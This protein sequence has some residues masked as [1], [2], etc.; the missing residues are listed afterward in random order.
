MTSAPV[1]GL[2]SAPVQPMTTSPVQPIGSLL[3]V[4]PGTPTGPGSKIV[5]RPAEVQPPIALDPVESGY[6]ELYDRKKPVKLTGEVTRVEW[7]S[8]NVYVFLNA[9]GTAWIL[10]SGFVQFRQTPVWPPIRPGDFIT[11]SGY[12][13]KEDPLDRLPAKQFPAAAPYLKADRL[14]RASEIVLPSRQTLFLGLPPTDEEIAKR[15]WCL[16]G[17]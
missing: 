4:S 6:L 7:T 10:E 11:V 12:L 15:S 14:T 1:Q 17:C 5:I 13:P 3:L 8:P 9:G 2:G 16:E